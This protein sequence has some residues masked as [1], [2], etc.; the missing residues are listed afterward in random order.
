MYVGESA[1][2]TN[3]LAQ[4][5]GTLA[6]GSGI[7]MGLSN[8]VGG[9]FPAFNEILL[10]GGLMTDNAN[11]NIITLGYGSIA[12]GTNLV[13]VSGTGTLTGFNIFVGYGGSQTNILT[14]SGGMINTFDLYV[15]MGSSN[16]VNTVGL[17]SGTIT[18][19]TNGVNNCSLVIGGSSTNAIS[20]ASTNS[21]MITGGVLNSTNAITYIGLYSLSN[22]NVFEIDGGAANLSTISIGAAS[23]K[24]TNG[25][26]TIT[27]AGNTN[28]FILGGGTL[29]ANGFVLSAGSTAAGDFNSITF[30]GG[31]LA[32]GVST[33]NF[34]N[35][36]TSQVTINSGGGTIAPNG[37]SITITNVIGGVGA[38]TV[39]TN[40]GSG[41]LTLSAS[42]SYSGGTVISADTLKLGNANALGS[43]NGEL[44]LS[45]GIMDMAGFNEDQDGFTGSGTVSN[46]VSGTSILTVGVNNSSSTFSGKIVSGT[47][48][49]ALVHTG[50]GTLTLTGSN[51]YTG[52]TTVQQGT[53]AINNVNALGSGVLQLASN[54]VFQ[55]ID[56]SSDSFENAIEVTSGTGFIENFGG[57]DLTLAG[58]ITK[59]NS[60]LE[61]AGGQFNVT[62]QISGGTIG[63]GFFNSDVIL[64]NAVVTF[65]TNNNY[66]GPTYLQAG[67]IL[68]DGIANA[69]PSSTI[70]NIGS[71]S[72]LSTVT[73][74]FDLKG[75]NQ[76]IAGLTNA[77][78]ATALVY[79]S[80]GGGTLT[81]TGNSG[82]S[83][84]IG[85]GAMDSV[86]SLVIAGPAATVTLTG[87]NT[88]VGNTVITNGSYLDLGATGQLSGTT[89]VVINGST[90]LLGGATGT[91]KINPINT[92]AVL[93]MNGGTLSMGGLT[94]TTRTASQTFASL[95]LTGNSTI[96]YSSLTGT[97]SL[98]FGS[99]TMSGKTL[100]VLNYDQYGS[101][102][103]LYD[104][105]G[106]VDSGVNLASI[107][108]YS[109]STTT[110]GFIGLGQFNGNEIIAVP[111]P[112]VIV[113]ALLLI[114]WLL[115]P[116]GRKLARARRLQLAS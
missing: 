115:F 27:V 105:A 38:L 70:L 85:G 55:Y 12:S 90:L 33:N 99:I 62:G 57:G 77:G 76:T 20:T 31:T 41:T 48:A 83:G 11:T 15:G 114:A 1:G 46:S 65:S 103:H 34:L 14:N 96:D 98:T 22:N 108:F 95:T 72:D 75:Y 29:T 60:I 68:Q 89:N 78:S 112:G 94:G 106:P 97:S 7:E 40:G 113:A 81:I 69:L 24:Y 3:M 39:N 93:T 5:S 26:S 17:G 9:T 53:L 111:E 107:G 28:Q 51:S 79:D 109:G 18:M 47:G 66:Y 82:F 74:G 91:G 30:N 32:A 110:S 80:M 100:T 35:I 67:S 43:T 21:L 50:T 73:N 116:Q 104:S 92:N 63:D 56:A 71:V 87:N 10:N 64:S 52:G 36:G 86:M 49:L 59:Q 45:A 37:N 42:N 102:T 13:S 6:F 8:G 88:Y 54:S 4:G 84:S 19:N 58:S 101:T 23:A 61:F 2:L 25:A 16:T 44:T